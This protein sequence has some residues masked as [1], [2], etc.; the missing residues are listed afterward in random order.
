VFFASVT[1]PL[2]HTS[3]LFYDLHDASTRLRR[4]KA[5][6]Q[7][8]RDVRQRDLAVQ[9]GGPGPVVHQDPDWIGEPPTSHGLGLYADLLRTRLSL[10][11]LI[12][13]LTI[14][15]A[16][17]FVLRADKV[18]EAEADLLVTPIPDNNQDLFGLGLVSTSGDPTRDA[19][20]LARLITTRTVAQRV[21][22]RIGG[23]S[24]AA[25]LKDV[26]AEPVAQSSIV[27]VTAKAD[28]PDRAALVANGFARAAIDIR[29]TRMRAQLDSI[30][31]SL[32]QQIADLPESET[33]NRD[34]LSARLQSLET[35][36]L[37]P[38]PTLHLETRAAPPASA[39]SPKPVLSIGAAT[40]AG[41]IL[42][43]GIVLG[44]HFLDPRIER[45]E[46]LRRYRIPI[47]GRIPRQ[48]KVRFLGRLPFF[49]HGAP[50]RPD[51]LTLPVLDE[52]HRFAT[53]L[54][55]RTKDRQRTIFVTGT[56]P[57]VGKTTT[58]LNVAAALANLRETT[59]LVEAD[60]RRPTLA[61]ALNLT[62]QL[63]VTD[64]LSGQVPAAQALME[65]GGL[66]DGVEVLAAQKPSLVPVSAEAAEG[67]VREVARRR[68]W[69]V[70]DGAAL[71]YAPD[72]LVLAKSVAN[73]LVVV[74][75]HLSR[76]RD[77]E[78]LAELMAQQGLVPAGFVLVGTKS[79]PVYR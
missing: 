7:S 15:S 51:E 2:E 30:I 75:L 36:R 18:Y 67:L 78:D 64:V 31:P 14:G 8:T 10:V 33:A 44:A 37:L 47:L 23:P 45:E 32:R 73:V 53:L 38:D 50:L 49:S 79:R 68:S 46:D 40:V 54:A 20:T 24:P 22:E 16:V 25:L 34:A 72:S 43:F 28:D 61:H 69:L 58:S 42:A 71:N 11:L 52:Y 3:F 6:T 62:P 70:V 65:A 77:L 74:N 27:A 29:T 26:S 9:S 41:I 56:G 66:A 17:V 13:F 39:S 21:Y 4:Q 76:L 12:L 5:L 59:V 35:L 19:E 55:A 1:P 63:D 48:R 57:G 60:T